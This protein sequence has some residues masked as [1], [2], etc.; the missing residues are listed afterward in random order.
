MDVTGKCEH[1]NRMDSAFNRN[2]G[3][4]ENQRLKR[5]RLWINESPTS[6]SR[7]PLYP[8]EV[9]SPDS[10]ESSSYM[11]TSAMVQEMQGVHM[12]IF[13]PPNPHLFIEHRPLNQ[14]QR[15][16]E[17]QQHQQLHQEIN[18]RHI[19][20]E[21]FQRTPTVILGDSQFS[22]YFPIIHRTVLE[23]GK[24]SKAEAKRDLGIEIELAAV[25]KA[26]EHWQSHK[27]IE[28][29]VPERYTCPVTCEPFVEPVVI[30]T[31][32]TYEK[33]AI[34]DWFRRG[35]RTCPVSN[36]LLDDTR[37]VPNMVIFNYLEEL[38]ATVRRKKEQ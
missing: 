33:F 28:I 2:L 6:S 19:H 37:L 24:F 12:P 5:S 27:V 26:K 13:H 38:R 10:L 32:H 22:G 20:Q 14:E 29:D 16:R 36:K 8:K 21:I 4:S 15:L 7:V 31:G 35:N 11:Y 3:A 1:V 18:Y 9:R 25:E 34:L 17:T 30:A 23:E